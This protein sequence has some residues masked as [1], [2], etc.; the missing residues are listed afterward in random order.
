MPLQEG[1]KL[2]YEVT[3]QVGFKDA[4]VCSKHLP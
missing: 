1:H 3:E 4:L 2:A